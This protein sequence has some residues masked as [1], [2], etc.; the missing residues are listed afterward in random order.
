MNKIFRTFLMLSV[1][2]SGFVFTPQV[3]A[4]FTVTENFQ[5]SSVGGGIIYGGNPAAVL[6]SGTSDPVNEGWLRLTTDAVG[7]QGYAYIDATFPSTLG[8]YLEFEYK[9]WRRSNNSYN[10]ADGLSVFL[11]DATAD[12]SIGGFGGS[13]GY[14][15]QDNTPGLAGGYLG[16][17]IDEYGNFPRA[18]QKPGGTSG[19]VPNSIG[20]R[21]SANHAQPYRYLTHVQMQ[22]SR[23]SNVNSVD[24][25]TVTSTRPDDGTFYR[26]VKIAIEP[27]GTA[28]GYK[29]TVKWATAFD[30]DDVVLI[31]GYEYTD[32]APDYLK[33]GFAAS[34]GGGFNYHEIQNVFATTPGNA[35]ITKS[36]DKGNV[37][38]AGQLTYTV[39]VDND[40]PA[41]VNNFLMADTIRDIN[42]DIVSLE[43]FTIN[44]ITF[45]NK[46]YAG[47]TATGYTHGV[48]A[49]SGFSNPFTIP[50]NMEAN[51]SASFTITGTVNER[52]AGG[53]LRNTVHLDISESGITDDDINNNYAETSTNVLSPLIDLAVFKTVDNDGIVHPDGNA[54]TIRVAN[55]SVNT[56]PAGAAYMVT[57]T[58]SIPEELAVTGVS[59][60]GWTISNSGNHYTFTRTDQLLSAYEYP[61]ITINVVPDP[62]AV[63]YAWVNTATVAYADID[64][65][66][67]NNTS[68]VTLTRPNYWMGTEGSTHWGTPSNWTANRV[69]E[70]GEHVVFATVENYGAGAVND[71]YLD[72][73]RVIGNLA[74]ASDKNLV[75]TPGN[76]LTVNE[77]VTIEGD[78]PERIV[79]Q[80]VAGD[81]TAT[82]TFIVNQN[83][84]LNKLVDATVQFYNKAYDCQCG[85]YT[86]GWQYFGIPVENSTFPYL[87]P[88]V[89]TINE[90][91]ESTNGN[92]WIT[93]L[94]P[95]EAFKGY[96]MTNSST[97]LPT[98]TYD[99]TGTL[100]VGNAMVPLTKTTGVNYSGINLVG[101]S[102]TAAI[103]ISEDAIGFS[104]TWDQTVYLFNAG[105][106]DQWRKLNGA[107]VTHDTQSGQYKAVPLKLAGQAGLDDRIPSMHAFLVNAETSGT[108]TL[109]YDKLVKNDLVDGM[110][111]RSAKN[112]TTRQLPH[113]VMD[114]MG[115]SSA[116]RVWLFEEPSATRGF[117]N[118][119]DGL[120]L[121]EGNIVQLYVSGEDNSRY[122]VA[123][124]PDLRGTSL[125][126][127][128]DRQEHYAFSL[129]VTA[130]VE[131]RNLYLRDLLTGRSYPIRNGAEYRIAGG[132][133]VQGNRFRITDSALRAEALPASAI[134]IYTAGNAIVVSNGTQED[135]TATVYDASGKVS[136]ERSVRKS[137]TEYISNAGRLSPGVYIVKVR[138]EQSI[139]ET[140]RVLV[141]Q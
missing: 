47:N 36:V 120:K 89:E 88:Q 108:L 86:R 28:G 56:K 99:F 43:D 82:G 3:K 44:S 106:R 30:G 132:N 129:S 11:F 110:A 133:T 70:T 117:D 76:S 92:K 51:S 113:I 33:L 119:W 63:S 66:D 115:A 95:L 15:N 135:C 2:T 138:G 23:T 1:I 60:S 111:W 5:E 97:S 29:I 112:G 46:G 35:R 116:D 96:E 25:N 39:S 136:A 94:T 125:G 141:R 8:V 101:N 62:E 118:G 40:T 134:D 84:G 114:V 26:K 42:G 87:S 57:V 9:T 93:P 121:S 81:S 58:D 31:D 75:I 78:N 85:T 12:F 38:V 127:E 16:I 69:P 52:P 45:N 102:Y 124:V 137:S 14:A 98:H 139:D 103:P 122:Q 73:D 34:T 7:Q 67:D 37:E 19:E 27:V 24:Y 59:G 68:S 128:P 53:V 50:L 140:K 104:G 48:P 6:T 10:G 131:S 65:S 55:F 91:S 77:L 130:E 64:P 109:H 107:T 80:T 41:A 79:V 21:G 54:Y 49:T 105:T 123:T 17:G 18:F 32:P 61:P 20:L 71:L 100:N 83:Y 4:Q 72:T 22:T 13:L 74:N 90:W 126:M